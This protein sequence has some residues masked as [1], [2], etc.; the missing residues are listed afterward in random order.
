MSLELYY[1]IVF[2]RCTGQ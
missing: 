1:S 2:L